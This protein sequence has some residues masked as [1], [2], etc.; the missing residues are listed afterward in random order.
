MVKDFKYRG[1]NLEQLKNMPLEEF[2]S[3]LPTRQ[4]RTLNRGISNEK[5]RLLEDLR[6]SSGSDHHL[7]IRTHARDMIILP[8]MVGLTVE[9]YNGKEYLPLEMKIGM[10]GRYLGEYVHTHKR[11]SHGTPGIGSSKSSLYVP[12]K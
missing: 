6:R 10:L 9:V 2:I 7:K 4:R 3:L 11:V 1:Y 5:R 8:Y 12:L